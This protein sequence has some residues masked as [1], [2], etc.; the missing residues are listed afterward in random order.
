MGYTPSITLDEWNGPYA[1]RLMPFVVISMA[2]HLV[3]AG[4]VLGIGMLSL[5]QGAM[6]VKTF[7][8]GN[9]ALNPIS[10]IWSGL[11]N[12]E[13]PK[14]IRVDFFNQVVPW[15][16]P[17]LA[18]NPQLSTVGP[19]ETVVPEPPEKPEE[20]KIVEK[21]EVTPPQ[22]A[23]PGESVQGSTQNEETLVAEAPSPPSETQGADEGPLYSL[24]L[25]LGSPFSPGGAY[26]RFG[27]T[28]P[29][30]QPVLPN[31]YRQSDVLGDAYGVFPPRD[32]AGT[33]GNVLPL[34]DW[35][36][37]DID[38]V[39]WQASQFL[40]NYTIYL[41]GDISQRHGLDDLLAWNWVIRQLVTNPQAAWP[42]NMVTVATTLENPYAFNELRVQNT[43]QHARADES[44]FGV[45]VVD[46]DG[47]LPLSFGYTDLPQ[48]IAIFVD[49]F[50]YVRMIM[51][52]RVIDIGN[53]NIDS[54][55]G[56]IADMW[57]WNPDEAASLPPLVSLMINMLKQKA[58]DPA[59][60]SLPVPE[61]AHQVSPAWGYPP[62]PIPT[63][64]PE[65]GRQ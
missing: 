49:G 54:V 48:P 37:S 15:T 7:D 50:G 1:R 45:I 14:V 34:P 21:P 40:G 46:R 4:A 17:L 31:G 44:V 9:P 43:L 18:E 16:P 56:V 61:S 47:A 59:E 42:P 3:V 51:I 26:S 41:M 22:E 64:E 65:G 53:E 30:A 55:M 27:P 58:Y 11:L 13:R 33:T 23:T 25:G 62:P 36:L 12:R 10:S 35:N 24:D 38:A 20:V 39:R 5:G 8:P 29:V 19:E 63:T 60:R 32:S 6:E 2:F 57:A 28:P 52:G